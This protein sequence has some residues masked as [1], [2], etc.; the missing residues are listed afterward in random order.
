[1]KHTI[2][3]KY[4][5]FLLFLLLFPL[6]FGFFYTP[7]SP[8]AVSTFDQQK[9]ELEL[10]L[11]RAKQEYPSLSEEE[12]A[13]GRQRILFF[14]TALKY[15]LPVW[16]DDFSFESASFYALLYRQW[17]ILEAY[18][19]EETE[20]RRLFLHEQVNELGT[21][22][23]ERNLDR[24]LAFYRSHLEAEGNPFSPEEERKLLV[25]A[26]RATATLDGTLSGGENLLLSYIDTL[27][28]SLEEGT[29]HFFLTSKGEPLSARK[30]NLFS[31]L[32][33]YWQR[34]LREG[35]AN[36][37]PANTET[38]FFFEDVGAF[39]LFLFALFFGAELWKQGIGGKLIALCHLPLLS[40]A[41][42]VSVSHFAPGCH[43][44]YPVA[45]LSRII[46]L[47]FALGIFVRL[48]LKT[49]SL[50]PFFLLAIHLREKSGKVAPLYWTSL[51]VLLYEL[52]GFLLRLWLGAS[53][54]LWFL[55]FCYT[56]LSGAFLPNYPLSLATLPS[57]AVLLGFLLLCLL[58]CLPFLK[59]RISQKTSFL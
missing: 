52:I 38:L 28:K 48:L 7:D 29:D 36:P 17:E 20:A 47:P 43:V 26:L 27:E 51:F 55:P 34:Q 12:V 1:M 45:I 11:E 44:S 42:F 13:Q 32:S 23:E 35:K 4:L 59:K 14:E 37:V 25:T 22:L 53:T 30:A 15:R 9:E 39:S 50:L 6:I 56:D 46:P 57:W 3:R 21:I 54:L 2:Y 49:L 19:Q 18:P 41:L 16:S 10:E 5:S 33:E 8:V 40:I 58:C 31:S 24:Y